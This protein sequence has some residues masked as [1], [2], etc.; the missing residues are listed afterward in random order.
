MLERTQLPWR[1]IALV[2]VALAAFGC[3]EELPPDIQQRGQSV[4][5]TPTSRPQPKPSPPQFNAKV[6]WEAARLH[7]RIPA[8]SLPH[9]LRVALQDAPVPAL[10]PSTPQMLALGK[11]TRGP[12][13]YALS[14]PLPDHT[15]F[16]SGNR[17]E[18]RVPGIS[19]TVSPLP[20]FE[21]RIT[22]SRG[23]VSASFHAFGVA[24]VVEVECAK[25]FEDTRCTQD[26]YVRSL[27]ADLAVAGGVS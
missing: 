9:A 10:A 17:M 7:R 23:I 11:P 5:E 12:T 8:P 6:D 21:T 3:S 22:R 25:P 18:T 14:V 1:S 15:V 20:D 24:Y 19:E 27:V 13:W 2:P 16:V 4:E 26:D